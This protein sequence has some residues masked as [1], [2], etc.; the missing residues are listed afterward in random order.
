MAIVTKTAQDGYF[1][2][3]EGEAQIQVRTTGRS[4]G[5]L[6]SLTVPTGAEPPEFVITGRE[7]QYN[8]V[9]EPCYLI[10]IGSDDVVISY[11]DI[12]V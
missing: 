1:K 5:I 11:R 7:L 3:S 12:S 4:V 9:A 8:L 10:V 6:N 2:A